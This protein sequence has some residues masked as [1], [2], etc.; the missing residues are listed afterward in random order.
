M[1]ELET[2]FSQRYGTF[3]AFSA[4]AALSFSLEFKPPILHI[5]SLNSWPMFAVGEVIMNENPAPFIRFL[6]TTQTLSY[7]IHTPDILLML[8]YCKI[9][10]ATG[11]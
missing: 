9:P 11:K 3:K 7:K 1:E 2:C 4:H 6:F 5:P 8:F 10:R